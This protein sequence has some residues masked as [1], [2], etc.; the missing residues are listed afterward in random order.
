MDQATASS[1]EAEAK[2]A[3]QASHPPTATRG[4]EEMEGVDETGRFPHDVVKPK[5]T[6][7]Y[8][9]VTNLFD[10]RVL[11]FTLQK[12]GK[13]QSI[14][15]HKFFPDVSLLKVDASA[16]HSSFET[17]CLCRKNTVIDIEI[18]TAKYTSQH[19]G[20][21][22]TVHPMVCR[23]FHV[24]HPLRNDMF[25]CR[26][27]QTEIKG[28]QGTQIKASSNCTIRFHCH[29]PDCDSHHHFTDSKV[30]KINRNS[31]W[32]SSGLKR[33]YDF[34][35]LSEVAHQITSSPNFITGVIPMRK[36]GE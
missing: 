29:N 32:D 33:V 5:E 23:H 30:V 8:E 16:V 34:R 28:S 31:T 35:S 6:N 12:G 20:Y 26:N 21:V 19:E 25:Y 18:L 27:G 11:T 24:S 2:P 7:L 14:N 13:I 15:S 9:K 22:I 1:N 4:V 10:E 3:E 36:Q 17:S